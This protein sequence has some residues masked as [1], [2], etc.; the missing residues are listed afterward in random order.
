[1]PKGRCCRQH[2]MGPCTCEMGNLYRFTEPIVMISL[3]KRGSAHGYQIAQ[4]AEEMAVTHA[5]VDGAAVYRI[6]RRMEANGMVDSTWET[7]GSGP[8]R[9]VY[10]LT[11]TGHA[12]LKDWDTL[13]E[14]IITSLASLC[15]QYKELECK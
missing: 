11:E 15:A 12:H 6:L 7:D 14:E 5:G 9:R 3:A 13:L 2:G 4:D 1:M 10:R 8:A